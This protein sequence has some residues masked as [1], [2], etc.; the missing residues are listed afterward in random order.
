MI[1]QE[2][3]PPIF[4]NG[5]IAVRL[6]MDSTHTYYG[7]P[8]S[9]QTT[10]DLQEELRQSSYSEE[11]YYINTTH[12]DLTVM[13]RNGLAVSIPRVSSK[14]SSGFIIRKIIKIKGD[15]LNSAIL[16]VKALAHVDSSELQEIKKAII[17]IDTNKYSFT[18]VM[19][20]YQINIIDLQ[21]RGGTLYH[22]ETDLIISLND[23]LKIDEHP[24]STKFLGI[25]TFGIINDYSKQSEL[26]LKI[27]YV[28]HEL[29]AHPVFIN[30]LG[31]VFKV[32]PQRDSPSRI[33]YSPKIGE[34]VFGDYLLFFYSSKNDTDTN[35]DNGVSSIKMTLAE[36]REKIGLHDNY[37]DALN[38]G[39]I[40]LTRKEELSELNHK[41]ELLK[42]S[43][44][45]EKLK[46]EKDDFERKEKILIKEHELELTKKETA[47]LKQD[48]ESSTLESKTKQ[49]LIDA[50]LQELENA[51]KILDIE[52]K[53]R[54]DQIDK[55]RKSF[56]EKLKNTR[57]E[58]EHK[59]K[60]E[61]LYWKDFY[62]RRSYERKDTSE[63]VK[64][65]PG[66]L[67]GIIGI[68]IAVIKLAPSNQ[69]VVK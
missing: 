30:I 29:N 15:S 18:S 60:Q 11:I 16:G 67:L 7:S 34:K 33:V 53:Y 59:L 22:Y 8:Y 5:N 21:N 47:K 42:Q 23:I 49:S 65:I 54:D 69:T 13:G 4:S 36:A 50:K 40:E 2:N 31:K 68:A 14:N 62:E 32:Y 61:A 37:K 55:E 48:L 38:F 1:Q 57:E 46:F 63:I 44:A 26:N 51:K 12:R 19:I 9:S 56:D 66:V 25:G 27:K 20:D 41:L 39:N 35:T 3:I 58:N 24:Y 17:G 28:N 52:Q 43:T 10:F 64:F 6:H 45:A